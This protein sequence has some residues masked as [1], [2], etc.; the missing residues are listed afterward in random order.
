MSEKFRSIG[1]FRDF[2]QRTLEAKSSAR[3]QKESELS[4]LRVLALLKK[5]PQGLTRSAL[6]GEFGSSE[7]ALETVCLKLMGEGLVELTPGGEPG[8][9]V[10]TPV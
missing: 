10:F 9:D 4:P 5:H 6:I 7:D 2:E 1:A 8:E 3:S